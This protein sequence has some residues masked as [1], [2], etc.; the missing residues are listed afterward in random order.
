MSASPTQV[1][2][3]Q[4][5]QKVMDDPDLCD[6]LFTSKAE[7]FRSGTLIGRGSVYAISFPCDTFEE[8]KRVITDRFGEDSI[9]TFAF[10]FTGGRGKDVALPCVA[11]RHQGSECLEREARLLVFTA[12]DAHEVMADVDGADVKTASS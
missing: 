11:G 6:N 4:D 1:L 3:E 7:A 12:R 2:H 9:V 10:K 5:V 8:M